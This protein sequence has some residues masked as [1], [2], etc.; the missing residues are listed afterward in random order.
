[1]KFS[2]LLN[3][4]VIDQ[5]GNS[6]GK[7]KN[8]EWDN[9]SKEIINIEVGSGGIKEALGMSEHVILS[10]EKIENIGDKVLLKKEIPE[11][12]ES[13]DKTGEVDDLDYYRL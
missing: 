10:Y 7:V 1:M 8:I 3:K 4:E 2:E 13:T 5:Q 12:V 11:I 6:L 9:D